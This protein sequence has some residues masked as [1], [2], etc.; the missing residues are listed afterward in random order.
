VRSLELNSNDFSRLARSTFCQ[1]SGQIRTGRLLR[2]LTDSD[3]NAAD[4]RPRNL[5]NILR[6]FPCCQ[7]KCLFPSPREHWRSTP[8]FW[9][10]KRATCRSSWPSYLFQRTKGTRAFE[11]V[12][13]LVLE[14]PRFPLTCRRTLSPTSSLVAEAAFQGFTS[15]MP[16]SHAGLKFIPHP[17]AT[18][19]PLADSSFIAGG[20]QLRN[21]WP[22]TFR[23]E[24][25]SDAGK[26]HKYWRFAYL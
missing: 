25:A 15:Q 20:A 23:E 21:P 26:P 11:F 4:R 24:P 17:Q 2:L 9:R 5:S 3:T 12:K 10:S 19:M 6:V 16:T 13:D 22:A 1:R 14:V 8:L 7:P 18:I